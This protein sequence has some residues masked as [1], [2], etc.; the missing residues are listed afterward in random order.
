ME[1]RLTTSEKVKIELKRREMTQIDLA[2]KLSLDKMTIS[3][4]MKSNAWK[5]IEIF[6]MKNSLG[7]DL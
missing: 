5:A 4:R 1:Q 6:Y 2:E 3:K 7:F